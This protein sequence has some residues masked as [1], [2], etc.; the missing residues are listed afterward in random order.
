M[1]L[2]AYEGFLSLLKCS[3]LN[4]WQQMLL[5]SLYR[6]YDMVFLLVVFNVVAKTETIEVRKIILI[7]L[8]CYYTIL[9]I[10]SCFC[11]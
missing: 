7:M 3:M 11:G 6:W 8:Q 4:C 5:Y 10:S 9:A 2:F 1:Y